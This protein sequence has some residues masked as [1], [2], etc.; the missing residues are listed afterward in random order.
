[1]QRSDK[2]AFEQMPG[3]ANV[4][5]AVQRDVV[6]AETPEP[7]D[8]KNAIQC[9]EAVAFGSA[10]QERGRTAIHDWIERASID[11]LSSA[12][13]DAREAELYSSRV[14]AGSSA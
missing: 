4:A 9:G 1:M 14:T 6:Y 3:E 11:D 7:C 10:L 5:D 2:V 8:L 12:P 13:G